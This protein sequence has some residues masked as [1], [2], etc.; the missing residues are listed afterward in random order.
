MSSKSS[1]SKRNP[2]SRS[3][4]GCKHFRIDVFTIALCHCVL[5]R[6]I[7]VVEKENVAKKCIN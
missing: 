6:A 1:Q 2:K 5:T 7:N 4:S 3:S